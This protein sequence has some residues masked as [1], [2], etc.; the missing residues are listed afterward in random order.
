MSSNNSE[1][2]PLK[3]SQKDLCLSPWTDLIFSDQRLCLALELIKPN[4][5]TRCV[6]PF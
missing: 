3:I 1:R 2:L 5:L 4:L 6:H